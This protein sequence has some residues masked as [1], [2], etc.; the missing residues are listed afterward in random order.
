MQCSKCK[1]EINEGDEKCRHCGVSM[2]NPEQPK[3]SQQVWWKYS[4]F[5]DKSVA[6]L[7]QILFFAYVGFAFYIPISAIVSLVLIHAVRKKEVNK[8]Y[9]TAATVVVVGIAVFAMV[10][11]YIRQAPK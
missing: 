2:E 9:R 8:V 5:A 7:D 4:V 1:A 10:V 3:A 6:R 11:N